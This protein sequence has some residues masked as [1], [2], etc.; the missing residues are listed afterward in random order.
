MPSRIVSLEKEDTWLQQKT[1][2]LKMSEKRTEK[3]KK[4]EDMMKK[5]TGGRGGVVE[6]GLRRRR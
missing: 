3:L 6:G 2:W 1:S 5:I 4:S